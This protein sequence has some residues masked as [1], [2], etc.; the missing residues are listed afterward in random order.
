MVRPKKQLSPE[1][2]AARQEKRR[3][4]ARL[5]AQQRRADPEY[6]AKQAGAKRQRR[7]EDPEF[8]SREVASRLRYDRA[9]REQIR[10]AAQRRRGSNPGLRVLENLRR[11][12]ATAGPDERLQQTH[13]SAKSAT[14][15]TRESNVSDEGG[16]SIATTRP[17]DICSKRAD[18]ASEMLVVPATEWPTY[19]SVCKKSTRNAQTATIPPLKGGVDV[20][21][22]TKRS[23]DREL[24]K[25]TQASL[26]PFMVDWSTDTADLEDSQDTNALRGESP[27]LSLYGSSW[28]PERDQSCGAAT[29]QDSQPGGVRISEST[30]SST[31][32]ESDKEAWAETLLPSRRGVDVAVGT[33]R[34]SDQNLCKS[35]QASVV[36]IRIHR[37]TETSDLDLQDTA[38]VTGEHQVPFAQ[39]SL[40]LANEGPGIATSQSGQED[41]MSCNVNVSA[42]CNS[43][44]TYAEIITEQQHRARDAERK[45]LRRQGDPEL[46]AREAQAKRQRRAANPEVRNADIE[47]KRQRR[48]ANPEVRNTDIEAKRQRRATASTTERQRESAAR[49][50]RRSR[51]L[52][53]P[54]TDGAT[55]RFKRDFL[56]R[57]FKPSFN[58][59]DRLWLNSNLSKVGSIQ[60]EQHCNAAVGVTLVSLGANGKHRTNTM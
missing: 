4:A 29:V 31:C 23:A 47:A 41:G 44:P 33:S 11:R 17:T 16:V 10:L 48:A 12:V 8:R 43:T 20:A 26:K 53:R 22:G 21:F 25:T 13:H 42:S 38:E 18:S 57:S 54:G 3:E 49:A 50:A 19:C 15:S 24:C 59:C 32:P 1:E 7:A 5:A 14:A 60:N 58:V 46:R 9:H 55:A 56:D 28:L 27:V 52:Q 51:Q 37:W 2:E 39:G 40:R 34:I 6:R 35:S 30:Y 36:P 45:R